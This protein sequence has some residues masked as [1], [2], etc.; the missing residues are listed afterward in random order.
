LSFYLMYIFKWD[1]RDETNLRI[2]FNVK[3][4]MVEDRIRLGSSLFH[5]KFELQQ[6]Y[7]DKYSLE[8]YVLQKLCLYL[9][10]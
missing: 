10:R 4:K 8:M 5:F 1:R 2:L 3:P 6:F 9:I 7:E